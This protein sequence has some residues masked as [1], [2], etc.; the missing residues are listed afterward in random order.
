V[1]QGV[2]SHCTANSVGHDVKAGALNQGCG[3]QG[4]GRG[5]VQ[6]TEEFAHKC[7]RVAWTGNMN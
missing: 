4:E 7:C 1:V 5:M 2:R 3:A 6:G